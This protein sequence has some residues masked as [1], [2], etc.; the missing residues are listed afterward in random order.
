MVHVGFAKHAESGAFGG[1]ARLAC[2]LFAAIG[3]HRG[4]VLEVL[5]HERP[6][7]LLAGPCDAANLFRHYEAFDNGHPAEVLYEFEIEITAKELGLGYE[8]VLLVLVGYVGLR[9]ALYGDVAF[10]DTLVSVLPE[11]GNGAVFLAGALIVGQRDISAL[12]LGG[13]AHPVV[14]GAHVAQIPE[15]VNLPPV[16]EGDG[17][18]AAGEEF[19]GFS[20]G[21]EVCVQVFLA[22]D[23]LC[24]EVFA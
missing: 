4:S 7:I 3:Q 1:M 21:L 6:Y 12:I 23:V 17:L 9:Y 16:V 2:S 8:Q 11:I 22:S 5:L 24:Q 18:V 20:L 14:V 10:Q 15:V 19:V 13:V